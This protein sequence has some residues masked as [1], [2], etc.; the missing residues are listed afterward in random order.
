MSISEPFWSTCETGTPIQQLA[1]EFGVGAT[2]VYRYIREALDML[3]A[4]SNTLDQVVLAA[5]RLLYLR[6]WT[7]RPDL[8]LPCREIGSATRE[9][10]GRMPRCLARSTTR[11]AARVHTVSAV[12]I[13]LGWPALPEEIAY[14]R[15]GA[16]NTVPFCR[17]RVSVIDGTTAD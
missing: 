1:A 12:L 9:S 13:K 16:T 6:S 11:V 14:W 2:T 17:D 10:C 3:A 8:D 15:A 5:S 7:I 4:T